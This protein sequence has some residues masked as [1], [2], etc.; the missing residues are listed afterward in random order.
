MRKIP[1]GHFAQLRAT[2]AG[3][4]ILVE[5]ESIMASVSYRE[6]GEISGRGHKGTHFSWVCRTWVGEGLLAFGCQRSAIGKAR[7]DSA[8]AVAL[9]TDI[10]QIMA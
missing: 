10:F 1:P 9:V 3:S 4:A 8:A 7:T 2:L 6:C 5:C